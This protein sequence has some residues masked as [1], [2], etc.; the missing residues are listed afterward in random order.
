MEI[1]GKNIVLKTVNI[2]D[3]KFILEMRLN[4]KKNKFLSKVDSDLKKQENWIM[5]YK[6]KEK[7]NKEFYF[8]IKSKND[9]ENLGLIRIYDL[10]NT[11]FCWGSWLIR[12]NAPKNTA[13]ES[14]LQIYEFG[15]NKL[16]FNNSHFDVRKGNNRVIE[17][18]KRF[19][20]TIIKETDIDYFFN[21]TRQDYNS[22]KEKYKRYM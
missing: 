13:I 8:L 9:N 3:A 6:K 20:A 7:E 16:N 15:F 12:E 22:I 21:Y 11:S 14:A 10:T 5:E 1:I 17:F 18:H 4:A 2:E 19:G